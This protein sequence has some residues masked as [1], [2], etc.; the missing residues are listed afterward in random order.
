MSPR[1]PS[2][3]RTKREVGNET[4]KVGRWSFMA[5]L[6]RLQAHEQL[7]AGL[8]AANQLRKFG[9][10]VLVLEGHDRPGGRVYTRKL[11]VSS[12]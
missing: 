6:S 5:T 9:F 4:L 3:R 10:K 8:S 12:H 2:P 1:R 11:K 7:F